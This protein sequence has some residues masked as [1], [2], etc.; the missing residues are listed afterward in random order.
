LRITGESLWLSREIQ[1]HATNGK[2][3]CPRGPARATGE[4]KKH[5]AVKEKRI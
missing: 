1:E 5:E 2:C 4:V 3:A